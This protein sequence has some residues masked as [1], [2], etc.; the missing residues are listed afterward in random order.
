MK[1]FIYL[2]VVAIFLSSGLLNAQT[3]LLIEGFETADSN[4]LP[5]GW[6]KWNKADIN[7]PLDTT[8]S[9]YWNWTVRDTGK[10]L[11][12]LQT[13]TSKS[14]SGLKS[15]GVSWYMGNFDTNTVTANAWLVTP[16]ITNVP[17]DAILNFWAAGGSNSYLDSMSIWIGT[18][19]SN[20]STFTNYVQSLSF[21]VG[22]QYGNFQ[23]VFVDLSAYSGQNIW[24]GFKY[25]T[26]V[27][28]DGYYV[29][30]DDVTVFGTVGI[31]QNGSNV[32]KN[33]ALKQNY[34]NPFNP[35][36][37]IS[38]DLPKTSNVTLTVYNSI[39]QE[40]ER[41]V[42]EVKPAGSYTVDF[43]A[44]NLSSGI[45]FYKLVAD[46]FVMTKKMTLVK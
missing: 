14:H 37:N 13:S 20:P 9:F 11:P 31:T 12:G 18:V 32:P 34:P 17:G 23:E 26:D 7:T 16:K 45:Y 10:S 25:N 29:F 40:V 5:A 8:G 24:I 22:S 42:N 35:V 19:D 39:G 41:L 38:F 46:G 4:N 36:T 21:P 30:L 33:F 44:S 3:N 43:N 15:V 28:Q 2:F 1:K 6:T 27:T